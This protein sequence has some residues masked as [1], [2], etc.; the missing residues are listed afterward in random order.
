MRQSP[1]FTSE[2]WGHLASINDI[3]HFDFAE[4][5]IGVL[6]L[7]H[8]KRGLFCGF[9]MACFNSAVVGYKFLECGLVLDL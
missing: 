1:Q 6:D 3:S 8:L 2:L 4:H 5:Y 7:G 9:N